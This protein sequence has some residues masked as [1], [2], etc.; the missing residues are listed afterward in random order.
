[1]SKNTSMINMTEG[2]PTR[3]LLTFSV[4]LLIGNLFQQVYNLVDSVVVGQ[5]VGANALAAIGATGSVSFLFIALSNGVGSG[6]G[7]I[8]SQ[9]LGADQKDKVKNAMA[10]SAYLMFAIAL[11]VGILA[12][13]LSVPLLRLL[14]TPQEI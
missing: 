9:Y 13:L 5:Y 12:F 10:N 1:M 4:P 7:I 3:L 2:N 8:T 11:F 14:R 6:G